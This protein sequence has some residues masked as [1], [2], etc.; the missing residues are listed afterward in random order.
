MTDYLG[1]LNSSRSLQTIA[2]INFVISL[3]LVLQM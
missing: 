1:S 3:Y 2:V